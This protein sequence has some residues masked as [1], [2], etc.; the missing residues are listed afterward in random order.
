VIVDEALG[1]KLGQADGPVELGTRDGRR[2][3]V[4]TPERAIPP[5]LE[6]G[7]SEEKL[8]R[9]ENDPNARWKRSP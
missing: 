5:D 4:F 3:G 7:I 6:P 2:L 8:Q 9:R 1:A